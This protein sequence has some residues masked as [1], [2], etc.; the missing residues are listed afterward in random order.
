LEFP[1]PFFDH[2]ETFWSLDPRRECKTN[3]TS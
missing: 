3:L 1:P 2:F